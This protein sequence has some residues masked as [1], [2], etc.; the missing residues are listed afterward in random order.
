M[1]IRTNA[2]TSG[3]IMLW[4]LTGAAAGWKGWAPAAS[5]TGTGGSYYHGGTSGGHGSSYSGGYSGGW[6]GGK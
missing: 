3:V 1:L 4:Y 5:P 6:G 2:I